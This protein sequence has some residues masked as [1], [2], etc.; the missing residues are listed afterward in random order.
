MKK[1]GYRAQSECGSIDEKVVVEFSDGELETFS[2]YIFNYANLCDCK[3]FESEFPIIKKFKIDQNGLE[4]QVPPFEYRDLYELLHLCR[5]FFLKK[6]PASF[7]NIC[8]IFG[9]KVSGT[10]FVKEIKR[11]R[12]IFEHGEYRQFMQLSVN[13]VPMFDRKIIDA[14]LN[15]TEYH[16][17][18]DKKKIVEKLENVLGQE[19]ARGFFVSI[20]QGRIKALGTMARLVT[21]ALEEIT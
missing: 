21:F 14:W 8:T 15:G 4:I 13:D 9:R 7:E 20:L 12:S 2:Q 3:I 10:V 19:V 1:V 18:P 16:H 6:E 11:V 5:P 17:D